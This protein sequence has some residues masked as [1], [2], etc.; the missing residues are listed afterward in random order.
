MWTEYADKGKGFIIGFATDHTGFNLLKLPGRLG[1]V[2]YSDEP[3]GSALGTILGSEDAGVKGAG[4]LYRKRM[5][6]AFERE[7]RVI[8]MLHRLERHSN[9]VFLSAFDPERMR[10]SLSTGLRRRNRATPS[11]L[12]RCALQARSDQDWRT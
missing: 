8:R 4:G 11:R 5:K 1:K 7:W 10:D 6:Y 2:S 3:V 9:G 12:E